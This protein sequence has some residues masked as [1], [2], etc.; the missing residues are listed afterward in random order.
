MSH[1]SQSAKEVEPGVVLGGRYPGYTL[2]E[3]MITM[4]ILGIIILIVNIV[5][6]SVVRVSYRIDAR[7]KVRQN[8]EFSLEVIRRNIKSARTGSIEVI[9]NP[10][11]GVAG[12]CSVP[13]N[14]NLP[15]CQSYPDAL[16]L[17]IAE[18]NKEMVLYVTYAGND[19]DSGVI[20]VLIDGTR[21]MWLTSVDD[22]SIDRFEVQKQS[23]GAEGTEILVLLEASKEPYVERFVKQDAIILR[24]ERLW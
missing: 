5:F 22:V 8:V 14:R 17:N 20:K 19:N 12:D 15:D 9:P 11:E 3:V 1:N 7:M 18:S 16:K 2:V 13:V 6:I 4:F 23:L 21:Q 10:L 24:H